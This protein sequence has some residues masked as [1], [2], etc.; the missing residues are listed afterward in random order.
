MNIL[1]HS[2]VMSSVAKTKQGH[3]AAKVEGCDIDTKWMCS[4]V[5]SKALIYSC[6]ELR[7]RRF[8]NAMQYIY[9]HK[10]LK[11]ALMKRLK[12]LWSMHETCKYVMKLANVPTLFKDFTRRRISTELIMAPNI[13]SL[14]F[15]LPA[16]SR[17]QQVMHLLLSVPV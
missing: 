3:A 5:N 11:P 15:V 6:L 1:R 8:P 17:P 13:T 12:I 14:P 9:M 16:P 2:C 7:G 10:Y 4:G